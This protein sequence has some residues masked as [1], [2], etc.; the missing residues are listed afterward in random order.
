MIRRRFDGHTR[1]IGRIRWAGYA[2]ELLDGGFLRGL[3][4]H[5]TA[6][7]TTQAGQPPSP[8]RPSPAPPLF[9][10][11]LT[12]PSAAVSQTGAVGA[13]VERDTTVVL[14]GLLGNGRNLRTFVNTLFKRMVRERERQQPGAL[15]EHQVLL[16]DLRHHGHTHAAGEYVP[17]TPDTLENCARDVFETLRA[18]G[19]SEPSDA[20]QGE[21]PLRIIGHSLGGKVAL[22]AA[23]IATEDAFKRPCQVWTLDSFPFSFDET[24]KRNELGVLKI[25]ETIEGVVQPLESREELYEILDGLGFQKNLQQWLASNL[26][27]NPEEG[28]HWN[29]FLPGAFNLYRDYSRTDFTEM[30]RQKSDHSFGIVRALLSRGWDEES[31][32][33]LEQLR[34]ESREAGLGTHIHELDKAGHWLHAQNPDGLVDLMI[35][36]RKLLQ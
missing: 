17:T 3:S 28:Y 8:S 21:K 12:F 19:A 32:G 1:A 10:E 7:G 34:Q 23:Q 25:L 13:E 9:T 5:P 4:S 31:I 2:E 14:H 35:E 26:V 18:Y 33:R 22:A 16:M 20:G 15:V 30:L 29:F 36:S 24:H 27:G 11:P 6:T